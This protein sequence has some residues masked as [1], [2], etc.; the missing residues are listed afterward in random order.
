MSKKTDLTCGALVMGILL[1]MTGCNTTTVVYMLDRHA[2]Y[3]STPLA[4]LQAGN[5]NTTITVDQF[6]SLGNFGI[7]IFDRFDGEA[8]L[9]NG[10]TY[11]I[12]G[13]GKV[14]IP[15]DQAK[16]LFGSCML[17]DVEKRFAMRNVASY[18]DF[19]EALQ[20]YF[21][22]DLH[23]RAL[24]VEGTFTSVRVGCLQQQNPPYQPFDEATRQVKEYT[25]RDVRGTLVG[26]WTPPAVPAAVM[27][28]GFHL[29]FISED[30]TLGG[31]VVDFQADKLT[32]FFKQI[33]RLTVNYSPDA[34][35]H[36]D[37]SPQ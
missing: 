23:I 5:Y 22:T 15:S 35:S 13:T 14:V 11:Q 1:V 8:V 26:F 30:K 10:V 16:L 19:Q 27:A 31:H 17:F 24:Q 28:S 3:Q 36:F 6:K 9:L 32:I 7:G 4:Y 20:K 37:A 12:T 2:L 18:T 34:A 33:M 25:W 29:H 21:S